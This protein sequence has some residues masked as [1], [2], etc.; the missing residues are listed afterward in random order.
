MV[1]GLLGRRPEEQG[2]SGQPMH[3][4]KLP[5]IGMPGTECVIPVTA[6]GRALDDNGD[7][8]PMDQRTERCTEVSRWMLNNTETWLCQKHATE[9]AMLAGDSLEDIEAAIKAKFES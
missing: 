6:D 9:V 2:V 8:L 1:A 7:P 4:H 5:I 3:W